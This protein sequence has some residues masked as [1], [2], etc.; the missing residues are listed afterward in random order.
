M[1]RF[2]PLLLKLPNEKVVATS[3][4]SA[5]PLVQIVDPVLVE[6]STAISVLQGLVQFREPR[7]D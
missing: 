2:I 6:L 4:V 3:A 1:L 7:A 5:D